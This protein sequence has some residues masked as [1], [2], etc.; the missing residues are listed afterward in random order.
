MARPTNKELLERI[1]A[2]GRQIEA[3]EGRQRRTRRRGARVALSVVALAAL[4]A[5][6]VGVF[7]VH[8]FTDV[9]DS[10]TFHREIGRVKGAGITAGCT[11]TKFC[12]NDH[13][14]R[15]QMAAFLARTGARSSTTQSSGATLSVDNDNPTILA[16]VSIKAGDVTGGYATILL[17]GSFT[18]YAQ[19]ATFLPLRAHAMIV[20]AVTKSPI[21]GG[22]AQVDAITSTNIGADGTGLVGAVTVPTG[23]TKSYD[24]VAVRG[25]GDEVSGTLFGTGTLSAVY[26]PFAGDGRNVSA[27]A[28]A[29][30]PEP[31]LL[32][33]PLAP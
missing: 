14:T 21:T 15:G 9:S 32:P 17:T 27:P 18:A 4:L 10:N 22:V 7:A 20:D 29:S 23:V 2:Q 25:G 16:T 8:S 11:A 13:V 19:S 26:I 28:P 1:E 33:G 24:L 5:V 31:G 12:P 6:P 3:L 30:A